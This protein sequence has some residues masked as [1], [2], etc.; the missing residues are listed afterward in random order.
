MAHRRKNKRYRRGRLTVLLRFLSF[1]VICAAIAAALILF[2]KVETVRVAGNSRYSD[3]QVLSAAGVEYGENMFLIN[4]FAIADEICR[5][6]PYVEAVRPYRSWPNTLVLEVEEGQAVAL[7]AEAEEAW[8]ISGGG[9]LLERVELETEGY[10]RVAGCRLLS[11]S[12]GAAVSLP[13]DGHI[14]AEQLLGLLRELQERDM[15]PYTQTIDCTD[16]RMLVL[17]YAGR[18]D[19]QLPYDGDFGKKLYAL[20]EIIDSLQDNETGTVILTLSD[21]CF[22]KPDPY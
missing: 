10:P 5:Q 9:K 4:K 16:A 13:A 3:E 22:F 8:L 18:F 19:V 21:R 12:E 7:V 2:F 6:L 15:L 17:R 14:T 20:A 11:P 1:L